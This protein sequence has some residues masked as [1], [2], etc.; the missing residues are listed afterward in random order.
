MSSLGFSL[1]G[2]LVPRWFFP[3]LCRR[4]YCRRQARRHKIKLRQAIARRTSVLCS[5]LE[6]TASKL[7]ASYSNAV[8]NITEVAEIGV[9]CY[10]SQTLV[11]FRVNLTTSGKSKTYFHAVII[12][13]SVSPHLFSRRGTQTFPSVKLYS[14]RHRVID[15]QPRVYG[16]PLKAAGLQLLLLAPRSEHGML[17]LCKAA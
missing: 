9:A 4:D 5:S 16:L 14:P 6:L 15:E 13:R 10:S 8:G 12:L 1:C 3:K 17:F 2:N 11:R 7:G